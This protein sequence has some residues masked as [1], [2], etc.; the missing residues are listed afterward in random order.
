MNKVIAAAIA[1]TLVFGSAAAVAASPTPAK[2]EELTRE[3][4]A[5]M[6][7]RAEKLTAERSSSARPSSAAS[8]PTANPGQRVELTRAERAEMRSRA[9]ELTAQRA[10]APVQDKAPKTNRKAAKPR[11]GA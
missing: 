10:H 2:K 6:R 7:N 3:Q 11:D 5:D 9:E 8:M 1:S 4:R